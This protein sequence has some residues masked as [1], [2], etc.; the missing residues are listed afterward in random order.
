MR[1]YAEILGPRIQG[2]EDSSE[3]LKVFGLSFND[4]ILKY[5]RKLKTI[6][7]SLKTNP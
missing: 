3:M 2:V 1:E 7:K 4:D 6:K 5:F